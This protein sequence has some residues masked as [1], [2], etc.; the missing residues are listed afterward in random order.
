MIDLDRLTNLGVLML[1]VSVGWGGWY[2]GRESERQARIDDLT[3]ANAGMAACVVELNA[4]NEQVR[5]YLAPASR[6][7]VVVSR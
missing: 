4:A 2:L 6:L 7:D 5:R 3:K 1:I